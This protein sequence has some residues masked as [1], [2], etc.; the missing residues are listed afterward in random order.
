MSIPNNDVLFA[1]FVYYPLFLWFTKECPL[2]EWNFNVQY[3][4]KI[5]LCSLWW[6][7]AIYWL[8]NA[9]YTANWL[10]LNVWNIQ[11]VWCDLFRWT[12]L[13]FVLLKV[14][15]KEKEAEQKK[16]VMPNWQFINFIVVIQE[17][18]EHFKTI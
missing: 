7:L 3:N 8:P 17:M 2:S 12:K 1:F 5:L 6:D 9:V 13:F 4:H 11:E 10:G 15:H 18:A 16:Y 14:A